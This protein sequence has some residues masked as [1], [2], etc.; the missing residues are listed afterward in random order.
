MQDLIDKANALGQRGT[1][2]ENTLVSSVTQENRTFKRRN[3]TLVIMLGLLL[4]LNLWREGRSL[5]VT[6][7]QINDIEDLVVSIDKQSDEVSEI[8]SY[9]REL[10]EREEA[11]QGGDGGAALFLRVLCASEDPVRLAVCAEVQ[12]ELGG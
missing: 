3:R 11:G 9:V 10:R 4:A 1:A 8:V 2:L 7:P 6:G 5:F 12:Q